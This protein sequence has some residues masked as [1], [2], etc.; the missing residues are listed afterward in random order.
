MPHWI[1]S[2]GEQNG[3]GLSVRRFSLAAELR[4]ALLTQLRERPRLCELPRA[5]RRHLMVAER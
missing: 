1:W 2:C 5:A 4:Y 3:W